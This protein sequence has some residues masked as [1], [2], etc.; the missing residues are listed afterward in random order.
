MQEIPN[1]VSRSV[2]GSTHGISDNQK[3]GSILD[4]L[5]AEIIRI[6]EARHGLNTPISASAKKLATHYV[7]THGLGQGGTPAGGGPGNTPNINLKNQF[8]NNAAVESRTNRVLERE[9]ELLSI[10]TEG[11]EEEYNMLQEEEMRLTFAV[12]RVSTAL[13]KAKTRLQRE[14]LVSENITKAMVQP[15]N[16][17]G[18]TEL[19]KEI[20]GNTPQGSQAHKTLLNQHL[21]RANAGLQVKLEEYQEVRSCTRL[22]EIASETAAYE[23]RM[24]H[25]VRY[26]ES[27]EKRL[28]ALQQK[29]QHTEAELIRLEEEKVLQQENLRC[30]ESELDVVRKKYDLV[31]RRVLGAEKLPNGTLVPTEH[32]LSLLNAIRADLAVGRMDTIEALLRTP[33]Y[34]SVATACI[35]PNAIH[36]YKHAAPVMTPTPANYSNNITPSHHS[37]YGGTPSQ[38]LHHYGSSGRVVAL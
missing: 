14:Q 32:T 3:N 13:K 2:F 27:V 33:D 1:V 38:H 24:S 26:R 6:Q 35:R 15:H 22:E 30:G 25:V 34:S 36:S 20:Q 17:P 23:A 8:D 28:K 18:M 31:H 7:E 10:V 4:E 21:E 5:H 9:L 29:I 16:F 37:Q 12:Q 19:L 11:M